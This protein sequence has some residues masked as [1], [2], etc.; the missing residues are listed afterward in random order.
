MFAISAGAPIAIANEI[1]KIPL[2]NDKA[3]SVC[4]T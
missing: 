2:A 3:K 1:T 4:S